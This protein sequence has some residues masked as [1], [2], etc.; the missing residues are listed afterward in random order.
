MGA[1]NLV[2]GMEVKSRKEGGRGCKEEEEGGR[3][4]E[5]REVKAFLNNGT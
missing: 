3:L 5:R 2:K 4:E 1:L